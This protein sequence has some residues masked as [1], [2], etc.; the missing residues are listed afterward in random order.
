MSAPEIRA[1]GLRLIRIVLV[2]L[3]FGVIL[4][5]AG[6]VTTFVLNGDRVD[7]INRE[8]TRNIVRACEETNARNA[9]AL[10]ELDALLADRSADATPRQVARSRANTKRL[11]D[12]LVPRRDC[13]AAARSQ[14]A[15]K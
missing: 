9:A 4:N 6:V 13:A 2:C 3:A 10:A 5:T 8:R 1:G 7:Q 12:A 11:I 14:V 15:N